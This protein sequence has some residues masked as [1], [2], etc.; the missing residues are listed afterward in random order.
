M[1]ASRRRTNGQSPLVN[2][3]RQITSFFSKATST[4]SPISSK[5]TQNPKSTP[6]SSKQTQNPKSTPISS[7]PTLIPKSTPISSR[8]T[9]NPNPNPSPGHSPSPTTP[10]PLDSKPSSKT[11]PKKS[12]GHEVVGKRIKVYWPLDKSWYEG[13]VKCFNKYSGKHLVQYDD[14]EEE[15]LDLEMEKIEWVPETVK[16]FKRLRRGP[17]PTPTNVDVDMVMEDE[18]KE[19]S[20]GVAD[21]DS[22]DEDWGKSGDKELVAEVGDDEEELRE[23]ED[24]EDD[25][26]PTNTNKRKRG[27][28]GG[29]R[30]LSGGGSLGSAKKTKCGGNVGMNGLKGVSPEPTP[31]AEGTKATNGMDTVLSGDASSRFSLRE[32]E[33]LHFLGEQRMDAKRRSLGDASYDPRTLYLPPGFLKS[34]SG[35]QRQWWEFKSKHMD[36][37]IFFKM[38]KF[39]E[40]FEMD[41]HIGAKELGLQYMKGEQPHCGFPE[42]NF[43]MNVEKLARK[44]YRVLVVEQ[45]ETPEQMDLRRKK[46]GSIDKVVKR[47][48]CAVVTKGTLTE[49][50]MLSANPDA[51]YLMAV[52]ENSQNLANENAERVFGVC[53]V[54]VATSRVILGQF[55]DDLECSALSCLLSELR[56]VEIV[57]PANLLSP[58]TEKVLIRHT[59]SPLVNELVPVLEFLDAE[60][61]VQEVRSIYRRADDQDV[62][63][64]PK[65]DGFHGSDSHLEEDSYGCLPD[66][67]SEMVRAG[68]NG[69]CAL[70][71]LGGALFYLKQA[72]LDETI[73]RFAKFELLPSSGFGDTVSKP[74]MVLD[75]AALENLEIFENNRNG[76]SSGTLYAQLNHCVT[77]FGKRL[78]RTWLARPLY[79]VELIKQRQDAVASLRGVNLPYALEFHKAVSRLPDMERL[80]VRV[81]SSSNACGRNAKKVVL[82]EDAAKKQLQEFISALRGCELMAQ[83]CC[84]L[85]V[86]LEN[87]ESAQ[88]HH[89][90]TLGKGLPDVNSVLKHF[91]DA[92]DWVEANNSGRIIP[93]EGVDIEYDSACEKVKEIESHLTKHLQEQRKLLGDKSITY[94]TVGKDSY[95]LE[96]P[97]SLC[98][99]IPPDYELRSSK[100]GFSRYWTPDIKKSL[101]ELSQAET[102]KESSLKSILQRLIGRFCEHRLKWRQL[103]SVTAEID[104]LI[105]LAIASDYFEGP[106]CQ[107]V[108]MSSSC[109][110]EVPRFSAK[111]LGHPVLRSDSLGK[112]TF[113]SNDISIGGSGHASFI[114]LTGP[115]MG[116]KSTLIRQV[117]LAVILAQLGADVPAE[118]FE[119]SPVD[120]IFV[121]MGAKDNIMV[122]QSTFLTELSETATMLSS[123]T[124]NSLVAL[125]ELGRGTS[126]SD[127]QAI[128]ESVLEHF[129]YKVQCRGMFSTHYHRL[130]VDYQNN[131]KVSLCHMACQVGNGD[132]GVEEV[133]FLYRLNPGACPKSYGVNIARLAGLPISV[134]K[135]A[136]A[137]S[138]EFEA[139]YGKHRKASGDNICF[140]ELISIVAKLTSHEFTKSIDMDSLT[141]VW[142]RARLLQQ[143]S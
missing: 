59:R 111:S 58:E 93:H 46:D 125:D 116:G 12:H 91:K 25:V 55:G 9:L 112:G 84:S 24:E 95:L 136:T 137:K 19:D 63:G 133:T 119:L 72:F 86:I 82:Y 102:D 104:V 64:S 96:M 135:K 1:S 33:K 94:V 97:E 57:K 117:C 60:R 140:Q 27:D 139:T 107:P 141:E 80:L 87:V 36:K 30:K 90:L 54:D 56:P 13:Y 130:A 17:L 42:K 76:D 118:S 38:G 50:E 2:P 70:S 16:I 51:S 67:L 109:T 73:L 98:S 85:N 122:G 131:S 44:G 5:Q 23:L 127:G 62:S 47:E 103:V 88:L 3:Q 75:S 115:N 132:G 52:T 124:R 143:E 35:G 138:R 22:S 39:Y 43:S 66:V 8:Q 20:N 49:G 100:K 114:L 26:V 83:T 74:Y 121:R 69:I 21:D 78:L 71:A 123:A 77:G 108:V 34:L 18:D 129:I 28:S 48:I 61:T 89:L 79:H 126:T 105:S 45:T 32:A 68:E 15:M 40:L 120:R 106:S 41:A 10:S 113:V 142:H 65:K 110:N 29:R 99:C 6:I 11:S 31:N 4:P 128:A 53:V 134:L 92:F 101:T 14:A 37:V 81:F 7:K